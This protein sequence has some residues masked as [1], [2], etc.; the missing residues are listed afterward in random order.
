[1]SQRKHTALLALSLMLSASA[2]RSEQSEATPV[3]LKDNP[4]I[5]TL[6]PSSPMPPAI[7]SSVTVTTND[8]GHVLIDGETFTDRHPELN[9]TIIKPTKKILAP[10][11][12]VDKKSGLKK[13]RHII[14]D[15]III[16]GKKFEPYE[17]AAA[18]VIT[19][20]QLSGIVINSVKR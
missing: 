19:A 9:K 13:L 18:G 20:T 10:V 3:P 11:A 15:T 2:A 1:M 14:S 12:F 6:S 16:A 7:P 17:P 5:S 4:P 8:D